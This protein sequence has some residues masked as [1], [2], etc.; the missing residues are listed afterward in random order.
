ME[1]IGKIGF[2]GLLVSGFAGIVFLLAAI[3]NNFILS[4]QTDKMIVGLVLFTLIISAVFGLVY[5][6]FREYLKET[7]KNIFQPMMNEIEGQKTNK[8][9]EEKRIEPIYA[10][11]E[12]TTDFLM[13]EAK[14]K[15][16]GKLF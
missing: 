1:V 8:L 3:L 2:G 4:D 15:K 13:V 11:T 5:V 12:E 14:P 7:K 16:S 9:L 10:V 6:I